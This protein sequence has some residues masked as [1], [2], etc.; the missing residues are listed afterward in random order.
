[1]AGIPLNTF[2]TVTFPNAANPTFNTTE[3][4]VYVASTGITSIILSGQV[5]TLTGSASTVTF[6]HYRPGPGS[7]Y[8]QPGDSPDTVNDTATMIVNGATVPPND[9]LILLSGKLVLE[10]FD[11]ITLTAGDNSNN[12]NFVASILE[13]ANQ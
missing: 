5:A 9:A 10:T 3:K 4:V 11:Y 2:K 7:T 8:P 13:T 6:K 1:M 12:L